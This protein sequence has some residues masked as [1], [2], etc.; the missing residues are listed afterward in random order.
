MRA[1]CIDA[2]MC[3]MSPHVAC[4]GDLDAAQWV[5]ATT[6]VENWPVRG[7][8]GILGPTQGLSCASAV[9]RMY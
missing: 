9:S 7:L 8:R 4:T 1:E 3:P 6:V 5:S 2:A